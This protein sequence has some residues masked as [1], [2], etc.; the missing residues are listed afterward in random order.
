MQSCIPCVRH[1][2]SSMIA[3]NGVK[4]TL[5]CQTLQRTLGLTMQQI[6]DCHHRGAQ[7]PDQPGEYP[8]AKM[9]PQPLWHRDKR[10]G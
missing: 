1:Q 4:T 3:T 9:G 8:D 6:C 10:N 7:P 5:Y 2:R